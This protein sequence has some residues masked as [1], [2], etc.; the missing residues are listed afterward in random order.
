M[1][2][3]SR[4]EELLASLAT[5]P[6]LDPDALR[7]LIKAT[8]LLGLSLGTQLAQYRNSGEPLQMAFADVR[9]LVLVA[10]GY[11]TASRIVGERWQKVP[12]RR[13]P[14]Y[15]PQLRFQILELKSLPWAFPE[16]NGPALCDLH[17]HRRPLGAR[18]RDQS[19]KRNRGVTGEAQPTGPPLCRCRPPSRP[20]HEI[21]WFRRLPADCSDSH[22]RRLEDLQTLGR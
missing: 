3:S 11:E 5:H 7:A 22:P 6:D 8:R 10:R 4:A 21:R 15:T 9:R 13:R 14:H 20:Y 12:E 18:S 2:G 17:Q 19:R 1:E 16:G